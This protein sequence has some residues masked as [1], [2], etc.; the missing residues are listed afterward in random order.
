MTLLVALLHIIVDP[1]WHRDIYIQGTPSRPPNKLDVWIAWFCREWIAWTC[2]RILRLDRIA[3]WVWK[4]PLSPVSLALPWIPWIIFST[5]RKKS[6]SHGFTNKLQWTNILLQTLL[7]LSD[8]QL[9]AG[10]AM[11]VAALALRTSI[12]VYHFTIVTDLLWFS[13]NVHLQG[14]WSLI[15]YMR[16][17]PVSR[18]WSMFLMVLMALSIIIFQ[19]FTSHRYWNDSWPYEL[20]CLVD[21]LRSNIEGVPSKWTIANVILITHHYSVLIIYLWNIDGW[22]YSRLFEPCWQLLKHRRQEAKERRS[23]SKFLRSCRLFIELIFLLP[24]IILLLYVDSDCLSLVESAAW[25][26]YGLYWV[27]T[28]RQIDPACIK[29]GDETKMGFGQIVPL[30]LL[31]LGFFVFGEAYYG[32]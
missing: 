13:M 5:H 26:A 27:F 2:R 16:D 10:I 11:I 32:E 17:H 12:S 15:Y 28:D 6:Q 22:A 14:M 19:V 7:V 25:F 21:D 3:S 8:Q 20:H 18:N 23:Y 31:S 29:E 30:V 9:I 4:Y 24:V 1:P